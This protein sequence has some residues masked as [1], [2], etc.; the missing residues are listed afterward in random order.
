MFSGA[1][2]LSWT[3][4]QDCFFVG[5]HSSTAASSTEIVTTDPSQTVAEANSPTTTRI[6]YDLLWQNITSG[7]ANNIPVKI[8]ISAGTALLVKSSAALTLL[9]FFDDGA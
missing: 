9:C 8:P 7:Q 5:A 3:A 1:G 6:S 4:Q 2:T